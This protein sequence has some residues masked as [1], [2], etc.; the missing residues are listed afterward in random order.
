MRA[1][2][3]ASRGFTLT[4]LMV[5]VAIGT[6]LSA[7]AAGTVRN[8]IKARRVSG[9][10]NAL[11]TDLSDLRVLAVSRGIPAGLCL[12]FPS[13]TGTGT[14]NAAG[15]RTRFV[16][17]T[18]GTNLAATGT[19][20]VAAVA[21]R[22]ATADYTTDYYVLP[23]YGPTT[24]LLFQSTQV[25]AVTLTVMF[26]SNGIPTAW[27]GTSC[28]ATNKVSVALPLTLAIA[29]SDGAIAAAR[30]QLAADGSVVGL[31]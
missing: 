18:T 25:S 30:L 27:Q 7:M 11:M 4:E 5:V 23:T 8:I 6:I 15:G 9:E 19:N 1:P 17:A 24:S 3:T 13:F 10:A 22:D 31:P 20:L 26:D 12:R 14:N 28:E 16:K 29:Q 2:S 21:A